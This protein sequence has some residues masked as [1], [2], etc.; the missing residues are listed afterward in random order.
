[1]RTETGRSLEQV[2]RL[3]ATLAAALPVTD[4]TPLGLAGAGG[5]PG[6]VAALAD[7]ERAWLRGA[8]A[9]E[10]A[11]AAQRIVGAQ[12]RPA[13]QAAAAEGAS[14]LC[15]ARRRRSMRAQGLCALHMCQ[16][17]QQLPRGGGRPNAPVPR[18]PGALGGQR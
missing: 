12:A 13:G 17:R 5:G 6:L 3:P 16:A 14:R 18:M 15:A 9:D 1:M 8:L 4:V 11:A 10:L 2:R 7:G